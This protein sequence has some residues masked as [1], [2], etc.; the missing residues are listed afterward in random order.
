MRDKQAC[1]DFTLMLKFNFKSDNFLS[2][3]DRTFM[4]IHQEIS[5]FTRFASLEE[6]GPVKAAPRPPGNFKNLAKTRFEKR[7]LNI[8]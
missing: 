2:N 5:R 8:K 4:D 1:K 3:L 6:R 7:V